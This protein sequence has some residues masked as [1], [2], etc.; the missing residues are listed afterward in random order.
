MTI[1][2]PHEDR[3]R[4]ARFRVQKPALLMSDGSDVF[5]Q[6]LVLEQSAG[7]ARVLCSPAFTFPASGIALVFIAE[8]LLQPVDSIWRAGCY[9]GFAFCS[10]AYHVFDLQQI[11]VAARYPMNEWPTSLPRAWQGNNNAG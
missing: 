6:C 1:P 4:E 5:E 8:R 3:R 2:W 9:A 11:E 7:G 10:E